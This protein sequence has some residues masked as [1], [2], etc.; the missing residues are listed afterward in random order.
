ISPSAV[1][2]PTAMKPEISC[3]FLST[4][5]IP[6]KL[7]KRP[8]LAQINLEP[9]TWAPRLY[10]Q[11][12]SDGGQVIVAGVEFRKEYWVRF[13][14]NLSSGQW[15]EDASKLRVAGEN[16]AL[17]GAVYASSKGLTTGDTTTVNGRQFVVLGVLEETNSADDYIIFIPLQTAQTMFNKKGLV[18]I[19]S[20]RAMCP[21]CPVG[22]AM[23]KMNKAITGI[24]AISQL[25]IAGAQGD[26]FNMLYKFLLAVVVATIAVGIFSIFNI[27][28]GSLYS[29][30]KEIGTLKAVGASRLQLFRIFIYE[31]LIV[32][33]I[34]GSGGFGV[35]VIMAHL[36]N[37][38]LGMGGVIILSMDFL[39]RALAL[40][41]VVSLIAIIYPAINLSKMKITE[42]FRTQW[43]N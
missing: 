35:G 18:S 32:G 10:A 13:W 38:L 33:V 7:V 26:F 39:Y 23:V 19:L 8:G 28:T 27:V 3:S 17:L 20:V 25:D 12:T 41:T 5:S 14:W 9:P 6:D 29:R 24:T 34:G 22:D 43:D 31:H 15:P 16:E 42:T 1:K 30:V 40:G 37:S 4:S 21:N 11:T 2:T 36:L